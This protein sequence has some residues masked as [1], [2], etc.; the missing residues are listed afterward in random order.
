MQPLQLAVAT[1]NFNQPL[2]DALQTAVQTG[3]HGVQLA[4]HQELRP[5]DMTESARRQFLHYLDELYLKVAS[6][7]LPMRREL[8]EQDSLDERLAEIRKVMEFAWGMKA[9]L[10]TLRV[11]RI[12]TD[13]ESKNYQL[14]RE[15]LN[16]LARYSTH[17]GTTL[18]LIPTNDT[19]ASLQQLLGAMTAGFVGV[20]F[21]PAGFVLA[22]ENPTSA[23]RTLHQN[24][25]HVQ[26]RDALRD[27][28]GTG[29]ETSLGRGQVEWD[30]FIAML[31]EIPYRGWVT[32]NRTQGDHRIMES[33]S[34]IT[35]LREL[36]YR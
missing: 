11:G 16:D 29:I 2:K 1:R 14:L 5:D 35:F 7:H 23:L 15:I 20:D 24:V 8:I 27:V 4:I 31:A 3:A 13:V 34:A 28:D 25:L 22:G 21:D 9:P 26:A 19:A 33:A 18:C 12:P 17:I 32:V 6:L 10:L 30:E 36:G